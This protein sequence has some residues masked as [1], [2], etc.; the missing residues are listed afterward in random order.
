MQANFILYI[1]SDVPTPSFTKLEHGRAP[2]TFSPDIDEEEEGAILTFVRTHNRKFIAEVDSH[3]F[4]SLASLDRPMFLLVL[5]Y[6][7]PGATVL[8]TQFDAVCTHHA[9]SHSLHDELVFGHVDGVRWAKFFRQYEVA[10]LPSLLFLNMS[11]ELIT[12]HAEAIQLQSAD[13]ARRTGDGGGS[14]SSSGRS[15]GS[16]SGSAGEDTVGTLYADAIAARLSQFVRGAVPFSEY[17]RP[18]FLQRIQRKF[19]AYYPWSLL[20]AVP[21]LMLLLSFWMPYPERKP[22]RKAD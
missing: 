8:L 1:H 18:T 15:S 20:T 11:R 16:A 4:R 7:A 17:T 2:I 6:R 14:S 5:D 12:F 19:S 3:N 13:E 22:K 10:R 21:V 9:A